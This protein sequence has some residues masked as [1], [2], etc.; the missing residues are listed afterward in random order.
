MLGIHCVDI[1][2]TSHV[3]GVFNDV[4]QMDVVVE[5]IVDILVSFASNITLFCFD[6]R[7]SFR[8]FIKQEKPDWIATFFIPAPVNDVLYKYDEQYIFANSASGVFAI[9]VVAVYDFF[10][11]DIY[12]DHNFRIKQNNYKKLDVGIFANIYIFRCLN[13]N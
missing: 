8:I 2:C 10:L 9:L 1:E 5:K 12:F 3:F 11:P 4:S 6:N 13:N 7:R